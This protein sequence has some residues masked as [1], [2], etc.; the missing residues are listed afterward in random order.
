MSKRKIS[1][2]VDAAK[3]KSTIC[4]I[5]EYGTLIKEPYDIKH[6]KED[7]DNLLYSLEEI[8]KDGQ[9]KVVMEATGVYHWP[10]FSYLKKN[11][12]FVSV[13]N[14]LI[15]KVYSKSLNFRS[16]KT[17]KIDSGIIATYGSEKWNSLIDGNDNKGDRENL[18]ILTRSYDSYQKAKVNLE[19]ILDL[20]LEKSMP[21]IKDI[22]EYEKL[23]DFVKEFVHFNNISKL[24][25]E[26]FIEKLDRWAKKK[27]Y[28]F[29]HR[30]K[31][32]I[33]ECAKDAI[34]T[35]ENNEITRLTVLSAIQAV[36][37]INSSLNDILSRATQIAMSFPEYET[38]KA[39]S[40]VGDTLATLLISEIGD[41]RLIH[42]KKSLVCIAGIDVP[43]YESGQFKA[44]QRKITKKG[45]SHLRRHLYLVMKSLMKTKPKTDTAVY[46]FIQKKREN[47][48]Y[49]QAL[50]AGMRKFLHIYYARIKEL[51]TE[52]GI[53][54]T[55][56]S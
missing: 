30:T 31:K 15:M 21:G 3:G 43:P 4:I 18:K 54:E 53:W 52:L 23:Y 33:Y 35:A 48:L 41:I 47:K 27:G 2:G 36:E 16:I 29:Q 1:V 20:E 13:I 9:I 42:N 55:G 8:G 5:D 10:I 32:K 17:D 44:T 22:L 49:K 45:N 19:Q 40:G 11:G 38:V 14:P 28:R 37:A 24:K 25:E 7:L 6:T 56:I 51:Y 12:Y 34:P 46:D 50:V 26:R 39:M